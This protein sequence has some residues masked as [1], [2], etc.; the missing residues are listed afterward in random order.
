MSITET[1]SFVTMN[2]YKGHSLRLHRVPTRD[3]RAQIVHRGTKEKTVTIPS[4][5]K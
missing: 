3:M 2:E 5:S 1:M 4:Q